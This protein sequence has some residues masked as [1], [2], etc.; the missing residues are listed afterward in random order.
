MTLSEKTKYIIALSMVNNIGP[1]IGRYLIAYCGSAKGVFEAS[2]KELL[3]IPGINEKKAACVLSAEP[4]TLVQDQIKYCTKHDIKCI[5]FLDEAYPKRL[6]PFENA[7]MII[8]S[9][10]NADLNTSRTVGIV[11]TRQPTER[12][13]IFCQRLVKELKNYD[14]QILSGLA[15]GIDSIAH[16]SAVETSMETLAFM[17]HGHDIIYPAA[18]TKLAREIEHCGA[19]ISEFPIKSRA[20]REHFPMR[21]R[22][23]AMMSDALVVVESA[24]KGG[25]MITARFAQ[26]YNKDIFALPGRLEDTY[27]QGCNHLIKTDVAHLLESAKDIAYIMRW[28]KASISGKQTSLFVELTPEEESLLSTIRSSPNIAID[29]LQYQRKMSHSTLANLLISLEFKGMIRSLPGKKY[30]ALS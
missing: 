30:L 23:I 28:E 11:G 27:S 17:G 24:K 12:G 22:L 4:I 8:Y 20:D 14:V 15:Y 13:K 3:S 18:N 21:N 7:P 1:V 16:K 26:E 19:L 2:K 6:K 29:Q 5:S 10:G 9:K 25:S